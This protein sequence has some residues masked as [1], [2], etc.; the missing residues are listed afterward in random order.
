MELQ[1][2][3][4]YQMAFIFIPPNPV[5]SNADCEA[6]TGFQGAWLDTYSAT[7]HVEYNGIW[8]VNNAANFCI[9]IP[10]HN[11][12]QWKCLDSFTI[13]NNQKLLLKLLTGQT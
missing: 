5:F 2:D 4:S 6:E 8:G 3:G 7:C 13:E 11:G 10:R 1:S 9:Q 12:P